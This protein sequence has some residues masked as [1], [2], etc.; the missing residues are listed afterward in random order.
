MS[1][2]GQPF[3]EIL[4]RLKRQG[5]QPR[6]ATII[7]AQNEKGKLG[8]CFGRHKN[9][10][11]FMHPRGTLEENA[12]AMLTAELDVDMGREGMATFK[13]VN[14]YFL[15]T[16]PWAKR[17]TKQVAYFLASACFSSLRDVRLYPAPKAHNPIIELKW[18]Y[19]LAD[20]RAC[21]AD[22]RDERKREAILTSVTQTL[23]AWHED[24][25]RARLMAA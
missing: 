5:Y 20:I 23:H 8:V 10:G 9:G 4:T 1:S 3:R 13:E 6:V 16:S 22:V 19:D 2:E 25:R 18:L 24:L 14:R 21:M 15:H 17:R 7:V 11:P 12:R